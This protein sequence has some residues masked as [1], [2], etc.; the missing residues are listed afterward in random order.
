VAIYLDLTQEFDEGAPRAILSSGPAVACS[1]GV[2]VE[3]PAA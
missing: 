1:H 3:E 2:F